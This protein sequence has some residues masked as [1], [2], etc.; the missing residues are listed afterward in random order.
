M[1]T[2]GGQTA[3]TSARTVAA[4]FLPPVSLAAR[5]G[6]VGGLCLIFVPMLS[7]AMSQSPN[8]PYW[9]FDPLVFE[10]SM[11]GMGP[12]ESLA[13]D[14]AIL[15][16][17]GLVL[18]SRA[19]AAATW[20]YLR[21]AVLL[22][23]GT[24][25]VLYHGWLSGEST[26]QQQRVGASWVSAAAA[27]LAI[28]R[29]AQDRVTRAT[30]AALL[31]GF[32][33]MLM[34]KGAHQ[35]LIEHPETIA[36]FRANRESIFA[37]N[38]WSAD[39]PMA[40]S[41][42]RRISQNEASGWFGLSNVYA[43]FAAAGLAAFAAMLA[44]CWHRR[45]DDVAAGEAPAT[46][47][48]VVIALAGCAV[49]A[50]ALAMAQS[51]GGTVA[52]AIGLA[53]VGVAALARRS[54]LPVLHRFVRALPLLALLGGLAAIA[55]RAVIGTRLGELSLLFRGF[56][57][58]AA[59]RIATGRHAGAAPLQWLWGVGPDGFKDAYLTAK[60]PLSPEEVISPHSVL[61][62]WS[63]CLGL[64]GLAWVAALLAALWLIGRAFSNT[65][66]SPGAAPVAHQPGGDLPSAFMASALSPRAG[67]RLAV[68]LAAAATMFSIIL[69]QGGS[70]PSGA[71]AYI[72]G[73]LA[74]AGLA[75]SLIPVL[76]SWSHGAVLA[77]AA[78]VLAAHAQIEVTPVTPTSCGLWAAI[79]G[80]GV[81]AAYP[82]KGSGGNSVVAP[83]RTSR[84]CAW[85]GTLPLAAAISLLWAG[86]LPAARWQ[87]ELAASAR[88]VAPIA[89]SR[90]VL[91]RLPQLS[92]V[93]AAF[94][95][96]L[97]ARDLSRVLGRPVSPTPA[98][99]SAAS[100]AAEHILV[101][102][103][104]E[105]LTRIV[106]SHGVRF[107][108][109]IDRERSRL[110]LSI[111]L[112]PT[113]AG[114]ASPAARLTREALDRVCIKLPPPAGPG[115]REGGPWR[116]SIL[117]WN[118]TATAAAG[119]DDPQFRQRALELLDMAQANDPYNLFLAWRRFE[120]AQT[121]GD[122]DRLA[123]IAAECLKL[124]E[125]SRLDPL[126]Q[127]SPAQHAAATAAMTPRR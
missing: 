22:L 66:S 100:A 6:F 51:K 40:K 27:A 62:D 121:L 65:D 111:L 123:A 112:R 99:I 20:L 57:A 98:E 102:R 96:D 113:A 90:Q 44:Q 94:L 36:D 108:W 104:A 7:R 1:N 29:A 107:D 13:C 95:L 52:A 26:L 109:R 118:A 45:P 54:D 86:V 124:N 34:I 21:V 56:Y 106:A 127:L 73:L 11:V 119:R 10:A 17:A 32:V 55:L 81:G 38:G 79:L 24:L 87:A 42:E 70:A 14:A 117:Q 91:Q 61:F 5:A 3:S 47:R 33:A 103:A 53:A 50:A 82:A 84:L 75:G 67:I 101:P 69:H 114:A 71:L 110:D 16:G 85:F 30:I 31:L 63:A 126:R 97:A 49:S 59:L 48:N 83:T 74:W 19:R 25:P 9:D 88:I 93:D 68:V 120:L 116:P 125:G 8:L 89:F 105:S 43:T 92:A 77:A 72:L 39:S 76:A 122:P 12:A 23:I 80:C 78:V 2:Q 35:M 37:A 41:Y 60:N 115:R 15:A 58:E 64:P 18:L 46:K 28:A 4:G